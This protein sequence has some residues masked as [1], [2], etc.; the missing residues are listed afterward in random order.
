MTIT[1]NFLCLTIQ[2]Y[3]DS[4]QTLVKW[5]LDETTLYQNNISLNRQLDEYDI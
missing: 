1:E 4:A 3:S 5:Q 2:A